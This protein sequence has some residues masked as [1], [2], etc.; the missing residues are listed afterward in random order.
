[1]TPESQATGGKLTANTPPLPTNSW[2]HV[3]GWDGSRNTCDTSTPA[4][5]PASAAS[6]A[7]AVRLNRLPPTR[8]AM[9]TTGTKTAAT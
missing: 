3:A 2:A 1:M 8:A 9:N 7:R 6:T 4:A 5:V